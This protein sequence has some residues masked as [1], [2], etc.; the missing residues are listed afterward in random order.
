MS[1]LKF[2]TTL[3]GAKGFKKLR[4]LTSLFTEGHGRYSLVQVTGELGREI[5]S[6]IIRRYDSQTQGW[7]GHLRD[8]LEQQKNDIVVTSRA[9]GL[10]RVF[11][12]DV[13][14]MESMT[15]V[16]TKG[17]G[18]QFSYWSLLEHG[19]GQRGGTRKD[20][21][22]LFYK[23]IPGPPAWVD[24][25]ASEYNFMLTPVTH[26]GHPGIFAFLAKTGALHD[27]D[28]LLGQK[29]VDKIKTIVERITNN[30]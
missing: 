18:Q 2:N 22:T 12:G 5:W 30:G 3:I 21:Y 13:D 25:M 15:K 17:T 9:P 1:L 10:F 19:W 27:A 28:V 23:E 6:N 29:Y 8:T 11:I 16:T 4:R 14:Y 20:R 24:A 7:S 26:P